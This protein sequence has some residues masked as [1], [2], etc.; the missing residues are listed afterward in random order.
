MATYQQW[1]QV[2][3]KCNWIFMN[4]A[5]FTVK[6]CP[7]TLISYRFN[8]SV[9][10][11]ISKKTHKYLTNSTRYFVLTLGIWLSL[12]QKVADF[13]TESAGSAK[14]WPADPS[15][16][17]ASLIQ[18]H[19]PIFISIFSSKKCCDSTGFC[20]EEPQTCTCL[21]PAY[22]FR[23]PVTEAPHVQMSLLTPM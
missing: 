2:F 6:A 5:L 17:G 10:T 22:C 23:N 15:F 7:A 11:N 3:P 21:P 4:N 18:L 19:S 8:S 16:Q 13:G 12:G 1:L 20:W 9:F 14:R